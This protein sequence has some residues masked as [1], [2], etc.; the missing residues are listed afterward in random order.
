MANTTGVVVTMTLNSASAAPPYNVDSC[1]I[2]VTYADGS[3]AQFPGWNGVDLGTPQ[4]SGA[5]FA[6]N[7]QDSN[8]QPM[9]GIQSWALTSIPRA[10]TTDASPFG[11]NENTI[12]GSAPPQNGTGV[13][14][15]NLSNP[16]IKNAGTWDWTLMAQVV[17]ADGTVKCFASDPEM[18][19]DA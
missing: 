2:A 16:K 15:L 6:V 11:T 12:A 5:T 10:P 9:T 13:F 19:V 14:A 4:S 3:S 1:N 7:V 8:A 17:C 18:K